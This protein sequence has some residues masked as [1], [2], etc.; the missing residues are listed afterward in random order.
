M[1]KALKA[2]MVS[3]LAVVALV[4]LPYFLAPAVA[5]SVYYDT[6][7]VPVELIDVLL[8]LVAFIAF[9]SALRGRSDPATIAGVTVVLGGFLVGIT[10]WWALVTPAS[11]LVEAARMD[12]LNGY[13]WVLFLVTIGVPTSAGWYA[14][15]VL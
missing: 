11:T 2:G 6:I 4:S 8:S 12:S 14:R 15:T 13:Q 1:S 10:L 9:G 3:C 7:P 5:V